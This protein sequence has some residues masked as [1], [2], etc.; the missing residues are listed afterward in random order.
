VARAAIGI[1]SNLGDSAQTV[2]RAILSLGEIPGCRLVAASELYLTEPVGYFDQPQFINAAALVETELEP[3]ELLDALQ[4]IEK[5]SGRKRE[6]PKGPRT[7]DL[8]L[9]LYEDIEYNS[10]E[11][12]L[13]HPEMHKRRF[14]LEPLAAIA[15]ELVH[16]LSGLSVSRMLEKCS[17]DFSVV[18]FDK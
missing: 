11:L 18:K 12:R 3:L 16:P 8:D 15:P 7:L 4:A 17:N 14:V 5:E 1:G 13:P 2:R 9:L 6:I 10:P